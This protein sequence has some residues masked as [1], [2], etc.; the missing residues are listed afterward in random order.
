MQAGTFVDPADAYEATAEFVAK[1][2]GRPIGADLVRALLVV[3]QHVIDD[4][5]C[6]PQEWEQRVRDYAYGLAMEWR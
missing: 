1:R 3:P 2:Y 5:E 4:I 6:E